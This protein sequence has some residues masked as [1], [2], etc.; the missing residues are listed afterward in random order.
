MTRGFVIIT[1]P[2]NKIARIGYMSNSAYPSYYGEEIV[3]AIY[4]DTLADFLNTL[5]EEDTGETIDPDLSIKEYVEAVDY[6]YI[7]NPGKDNLKCYTYGKC[8]FDGAPKSDYTYIKYIMENYD[9][10]R[11]LSA[12]D[13]ETLQLKPF[14]PLSLCKELKGS[15]LSILKLKL[16]RLP[17]ICW[18]ERGPMYCVSVIAKPVREI[19][20]YGRP[21]KDDVDDAESTYS[22][23]LAR[24]EVVYYE[25]LKAYEIQA[26]THVT[27][28]DE[29]SRSVRV[30]SRN[31]LLKYVPGFIPGASIYGSRDRGNSATK[32]ASAIKEFV[33]DSARDFEQLMNATICLRES[34]L[35]LQEARTK[36]ELTAIDEK[37]RSDVRPYFEKMSSGAKSLF[38]YLD[39]EKTE[40][41]DSWEEAM[42]NA[43]MD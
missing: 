41:F 23:E 27:M 11:D 16:N 33:R 3:T 5:D 2:K 25:G 30:E 37:L 39:M 42:K 18:E 26:F 1:G 31:M 10:L 29:Y 8:F 32:T 43:R 20:V 35:V 17:N 12:M 21:P 19:V 34:V 38:P 24:F 6:A 14:S 36:E 40:F 9:A 13:M 7:Y 4:K 22:L 15:N 28:L